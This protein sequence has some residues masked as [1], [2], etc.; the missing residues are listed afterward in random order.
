MRIALIAA[1][2][3]ILD[4]MVGDMSSA[5]F[6][7]YTQ[8][9]VCFKAGPEFSLLQGHLLLL[10]VNYMV[11]ETLVLVGMIAYPMPYG[12]W[13]ISKAKQIQTYGL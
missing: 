5:Y 11:S 9:K 6:E 1:E 13:D 2:I 3:N 10:S 4:I 12:T 8:E 7:A